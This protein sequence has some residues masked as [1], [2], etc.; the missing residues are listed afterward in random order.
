MIELRIQTGY[1]S[2]KL[3]FTLFILHSNYYANFRFSISFYK[4]TAPDSGTVL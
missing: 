3:Y 2:R 1:A 4:K